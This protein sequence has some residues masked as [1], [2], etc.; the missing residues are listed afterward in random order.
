MCA[1]KKNRLFP[2]PRSFDAGLK[3]KVSKIELTL[4]KIWSVI[5][6]M[7]SNIINIIFFV[8]SLY[9]TSRISHFPRSTAFGRFSLN[10]V[11]MYDQL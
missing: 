7:I 4:P 10:C 2:S 9:S 6:Q 11:T 3:G 1:D 5:N 8:K